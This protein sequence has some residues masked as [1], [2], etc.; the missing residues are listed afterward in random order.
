MCNTIATCNACC[1]ETFD[2]LGRAAKPK[3]LKCQI[4]GWP[5]QKFLV[6]SQ[7]F[8][9]SFLAVRY[10]QSAPIPTRTLLFIEKT[11]EHCLHRTLTALKPFSREMSCN[12]WCQCC[13]EDQADMPKDKLTVKAD[14]KVLPVAL[15]DS[16]MGA[17]S[18]SKGRSIHTLCTSNGSPYLNYQTRIM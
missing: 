9:L 11:I 10:E 3:D 8:S 13:A 16:S 6:T 18:A 12:L 1:R 7:S 2:L 14:D 15:T 5:L 4:L 17:A